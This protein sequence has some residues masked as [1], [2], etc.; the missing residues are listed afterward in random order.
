MRIKF[1]ASL[2]KGANTVLDIGTDHAKVLIEALKNG[3]IKKGIGS[4]INEGPLKNALKNID[5]A[6][7]K[8]KIILVQSDGFKKITNSCDVVVITGMGYELIKSILQQDH[9]APKYYLLGAHYQVELL[10]KYL[11]E[12]NYQIIDEYLFFEKKYYLFLKVINKKALLEEEDYYLGPILK[13]KQEALPYY[14]DELDKLLK[15]K[16]HHR[17]NQIKKQ[18]SLL[19]EAITNLERQQN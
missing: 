6:Q 15:I 9:Q 8:D 16:E 14:K 7:L 19:K 1:I 13:T 12:H 10:R 3:Y 17:S 11:A 2:L 5:K 4:D 18:I